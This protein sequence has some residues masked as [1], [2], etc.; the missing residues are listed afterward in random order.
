MTNGPHHA[1]VMMW[2]K[3]NI[4]FLIILVDT[5]ER[6]MKNDKQMDEIHIR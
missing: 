3:H 6:L 4:T 5:L 2:L 1:Y